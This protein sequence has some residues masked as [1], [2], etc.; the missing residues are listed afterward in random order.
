MT[1]L[2]LWLS[3]PEVIQE[4]RPRLARSR[5]YRDEIF[6]MPDCD[7]VDKNRRKI[8]SFLIQNGR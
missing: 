2:S 3:N 1:N 4:N 5:L 6:A 7:I 8:F